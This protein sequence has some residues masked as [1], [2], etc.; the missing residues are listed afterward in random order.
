M[1][2]GLHRT[3]PGTPI[4]ALA[5]LLHPANA[6]AITFADGFA[7]ASESHGS[8]I[9][10]HYSGEIFWAV[11]RFSSSSPFEDLVG[12]EFSGSFTF[13]T[14]EIDA[15]IPGFTNFYPAISSDLFI[16]PTHFI[17]FINFDAPPLIIR[18]DDL[19][20]SADSSPTQGHEVDWTFGGIDVA[21]TRVGLE[22]SFLGAPSAQYIFDGLND[23]SLVNGDF[24]E[25]G[26][27]IVI[28]GVEYPVATSL[29]IQVVEQ[30]GPGMFDILIHDIYGDVLQ[31]AVP[32]PSTALLHASALVAL[33]ALAVRRRG[34]L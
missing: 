14:D 29:H 10:Y 21:R 12:Q 5:L 20:V 2:C 4:L 31:L 33:A 16:D 25:F 17:D 9:T 13:D 26:I 24:T 32:E 22:L 7:T 28:D 8:A 18:G 11:T 27:T 6:V 23:G 30:T 15:L 3:L 19:L 1:L 34:A